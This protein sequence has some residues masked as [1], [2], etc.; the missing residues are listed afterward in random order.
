MSNSETLIISLRYTPLA[1][2]KWKL[3]L[4]S[5]NQVVPWGHCF[6]RNLKKQKLLILPWPMY[7][8]GQWE[9]RGRLSVA[10]SRPLFFC[11]WVIPAW[12][13]YLQAVTTTTPHCC[14]PLLPSPSLNAWSSLG[15]E[16]PP[17]VILSSLADSVPPPAA[18]H[19]RP[20]LP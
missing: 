20:L 2:N 9:M 5:E 8:K 13:S 11:P 19:R 12:D 16:G 3:L 17:L 15:L 1:F 10:T 14:S 6:L 7:Y 4:L 18:R